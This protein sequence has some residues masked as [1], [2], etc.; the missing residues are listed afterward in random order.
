MAPAH[1]GVR[2]SASVEPY[3]EVPLAFKA[4]GYVH[5]LLAIR[6][7]ADGPV[8]P[9]QA[10]DQVHEEA[11]CWPGSTTRTIASG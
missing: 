3:Q 11:L 10:G 2:Y 9:A 1:A 7:G 6:R 5:P 8:R 4:S